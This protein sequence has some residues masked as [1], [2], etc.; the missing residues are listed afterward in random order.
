MSRSEVRSAADGVSTEVGSATRASWAPYVQAKLGFRNYW[1]P[2]MFAAE[3]DG[4]DAKGVRLLG[5]NVLLRPVGDRI[6]AVEDR[7]L[8]RGVR[9]SR[10]PECYTAD[11]I[12]CWYHGFTY[13]LLDGKLVDI[14]T[15]PGS[16]MIGRIGIRPYPGP[17]AKG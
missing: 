2:A 15:E 4:G 13:N 5:E 10:K 1:Y 17:A 14:L 8:H 9:F 3:L 16:K 7:C 11:T 6:A 12:T